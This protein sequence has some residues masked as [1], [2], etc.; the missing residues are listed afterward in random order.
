MGIEHGGDDR[1]W[2]EREVPG[3]AT[4]VGLVRKQT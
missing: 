1:F 4:N 3:Y 2:H